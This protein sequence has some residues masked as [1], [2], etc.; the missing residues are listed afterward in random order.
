MRAPCDAG[1]AVSC[2]HTTVGTTATREGP[3]RVSSVA[4][5][6][7]RERRTRPLP[8]SRAARDA[9]TER[10]R[11]T[12]GERASTQRVRH[13]VLQP[14]RQMLPGGYTMR[15]SPSPDGNSRQATAAYSAR[16]TATS[17][18]SHAHIGGWHRG[19]K[20][21]CR[22][23]ERKN[24]NNNSS[25]VH[26]T[27]RFEQSYTRARTARAHIRAQQSAG[28]AARGDGR[29]D[30]TRPAGAARV[31]RHTTSTGSVCG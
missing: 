9:R 10:G 15:G 5:H 2:V 12:R 8:P 16:Q 25:M 29:R 22:A 31:Q 24:D 11:I 23:R 14:T 17:A 13:G 28:A 26:V 27:L 1:A 6:A 20:G 19:Q 7:G 18:I 3:C 30:G 21:S 4:A